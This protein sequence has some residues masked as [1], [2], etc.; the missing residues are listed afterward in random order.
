[1]SES[2]ARACAEFEQIMLAQ[3]LRT[4]GIAKRSRIG[5]DDDDADADSTRD[6]DDAF[7]QLLVQALSGA[8]ERAGGIGLARSL[9]DALARGRS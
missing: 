2:L 3:M 8:L 7:S 4:A 5:G 6:R 1:M 9:H